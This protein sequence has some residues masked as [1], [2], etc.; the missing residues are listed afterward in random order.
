M[1]M[2]F[3]YDVR[4]NLWARSGRRE[5]KELVSE[6][7]TASE[8]NAII[9]AIKQLGHTVEVVDGAESFR[10]RI[11]TYQNTDFVFNEAKG[12]YGPDRKMLVPALCR[13]YNI[14]YL[15]SDAYT[16]TL[17]RNKWH[18]ASIARALGVLAPKSQLART[19]V[20]SVTKRWNTF[21]AIVKP[22]HESASIGVSSESVVNS[23]AELQDQVEKVLDTYNQPAIIEEFIAGA[24]I[25][26][27]VIGNEES[28]RINP[29]RLY[30]NGREEDPYFFVRKEDWQRDRVYFKRFALESLPRAVEE[31]TRRLYMALG[32][33]DYGRL[34]FRLSRDGRPYFIEAATHPHL[35]PQAS[36]VEAIAGEELTFHDVVGLVL[37]A[38]FRRQR[39]TLAQA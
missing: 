19:S 11:E 15:G 36:F 24:E 23:A 39:L 27:S 9:K 33:R 7:F 38:S 30:V 21:P 10:D 35:V 3:V 8:A 32:I 22:N 12:L 25:Q 37:D 17:A 31:A 18:T 26:V 5:D 13:V 16:V 4:E 6:L 29:S 34:D 20:G 1:R 2:I 14:P 28:L